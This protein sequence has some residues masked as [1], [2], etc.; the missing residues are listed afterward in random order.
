MHKIYEGGVIAASIKNVS[1]EFISSELVEAAMLAFMSRACTSSEFVNIMKPFVS[2]HMLNPVFESKFGKLLS[3]EFKMKEDGGEDNMGNKKCVKR[4]DLMVHGG[5]GDLLYRADELQSPFC[6]IIGESVLGEI[7]IE[8]QPGTGKRAKSV[9]VDDIMDERISP[10]VQLEGQEKGQ[11]RVIKILETNGKERKQSGKK[12]ESVDDRSNKLV[13]GRFFALKNSLYNACFQLGKIVSGHEKSATSKMLTQVVEVPTRSKGVSEMEDDCNGFAT[14]LNDLQ[15]VD[16]VKKRVCVKKTGKEILDEL[17]WREQKVKEGRAEVVKNTKIPEVVNKDVNPG[18]VMIFKAGETKEMTEERAKLMGIGKVSYAAATSGAKSK[19]FNDLIKYSPPAVLENGE[20][21]VLVEPT[22]VEKAKTV[23]SNSLYGY[24]VGSYVRLDFVRF[25]LYK[26]WKKYGVKDISSNGNGIFYFKF[27]SVEGMEEVLKAGP[28][29]VNNVPLCLN[30]WEPAICLS[31]PE[32]KSVPVW[33]VFKNLPL[34]LWSTEWICKVASCIGKPITFDNATKFRCANSGGAGGFARV[35]VE[36]EVKDIFP[37]SVKIIYLREGEM[38]NKEVL[39]QVEYHGMPINCRHCKVFGH[40]FDK[41]SVRPMTEDEK[42][43]HEINQ[44]KVDSSKGKS[45]KVDEDGFQQPTKRFWNV[46]P[47][48]RQMNNGGWQRNKNQMKFG[49]GGQWQQSG[50]KF[51]Y[52][53]HTVVGST[54]GQVYECLNEEKAEGVKSM[55]S[56]GGNA[57]N[58]NGGNIGGSGN[59]GQHQQGKSSQ[60]KYVKVNNKSK[61]VTKGDQGVKIQNRFNSLEHMGD[62]E[63]DLCNLHRPD[64]VPISVKSVDGKPPT[65]EPKKLYLG[66]PLTVSQ[67]AVVKAVFDKKLAPNVDI[68]M[69][70]SNAQRRYF[71]WL[72][73]DNNFEEGLKFMSKAD[74]LMEV[75]VES[76]TDETARF[77]TKG[78]GGYSADNED[79]FNDGDFDF[80]GSASVLGRTVVKDDC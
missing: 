11:R 29:I 22:I 39:I 26:M 37:E 21:V 28:W 63:T 16:V 48:A 80:S 66:V 1:Q 35:L 74:E 18:G 76:E 15:S 71:K 10:G 30:R 9:M 20:M 12:A 72:C 61:N 70:W 58:S 53:Q 7:V 3:Y 59:L 79:A 55:G 27:Q 5:V 42:K 8:K 45:V 62:D 25:N 2:F 68:F 57:S 56:Y 38:I 19:E 69:K 33:V 67:E 36:V 46:R 4:K 34:E 17:K 47:P 73:L 14:N 24:F 50:K 77:L 6:S 32:P 78:V 31:K 52:K 49:M 64:T 54:S 51:E 75:E 41:C 23:Y 13:G 60:Q 40:L 43:A 44:K 65:Y